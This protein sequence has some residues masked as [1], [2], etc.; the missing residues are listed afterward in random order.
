M[1]LQSQAIATGV[2]IL[3]LTPRGLKDGDVPPVPV[4]PPPSLSADRIDASVLHRII[5]PITTIT[6]YS[7]GRVEH[8]TGSG[9]VAGNRFYTVSHNLDCSEDTPHVR[10]TSYIDGVQVTPL[11]EN[12]GED[13]AIFG[14]PD[15]LCR[16]HCNEVTLD[17][18]VMPGQGAKL[19]WMR[20]FRGSEVLREARVVDIAWLGCAPT[21]S[22]VS[23]GC[24]V[25][26]V[27]RPF[28]QGSS[29]SPV[30]DSDTGRIVG[31]IQG[32]L[33]GDGGELGFFRPISRVI[34]RVSDDARRRRGG[35]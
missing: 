20:R 12:E 16:Q 27:D 35:S 25:V 5:L 3:L 22:E 10:K 15:P 29:G 28:E 11:Y 13:L 32:S 8:N 17:A 23:S 7:D 19:T 26:L 18:G 1:T 21:G 24:E 14:I 9:F 2:L 30:V 6:E 34:D 33:S 4:P 31:I